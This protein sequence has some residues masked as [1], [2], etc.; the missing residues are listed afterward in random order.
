MALTQPGSDKARPVWGMV[1][2]RKGWQL[3]SAVLLAWALS[4]VLGLQGGWWAVMSALIIVRPGAD[5]TLD[6]GWARARGTALGSAVALLGAGLQAQGLHT[7]AVTLLVVGALAFWSAAAPGWRSA[8]ITALIVLQASAMPG[9]SAWQV[10]L[11]RIA[12]IAVG[13]VAGVLVTLPVAR[14]AAAARF[15]ARCAELLRLWAE[16]FPA[17][18]VP[19]VPGNAVDTGHWRT[20]LYELSVLGRSVDQAGRWLRR[21]RSS[22]TIPASRETAARLMSRTF[23]DLGA[24]SRLVSLLPDGSAA[25]AVEILNDPVARALRGASD[26]LQG[27]GQ[28]D[29]AALRQLALS[30]RTP[31]SGEAPSASSSRWV[32]PGVALLVQDLAALA[33]WR[34]D[35]APTSP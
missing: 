23:A 27:R 12:E 16:E 5:S 3:A 2:L 1:S 34:L 7:I 24:L 28:A 10:A 29:L 30:Q 31:P 11:L 21:W 19:A 8:P 18:R 25:E 33:R 22:A 6:A 26:A 13:V 32:A 20:A 17:I 15:D 14:Q 9:H 4:S 35:R